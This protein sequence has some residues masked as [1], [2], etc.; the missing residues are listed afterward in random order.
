MPTGNGGLAP[1]PQNAGFKRPVPL[2][3]AARTPPSHRARFFRTVEPVLDHR[4]HKVAPALSRASREI[5]SPE[6]PSISVV[7]QAPASWE[8]ARLDYRRQD[9]D[10]LREKAA[11]FRELAARH[12]TRV[13]PE[14]LA[15]ADDLEAYAAEIEKRPRL[16]P[17][18]RVG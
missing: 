16:V 17:D 5:L 1:L 11:R 6:R 10:Y 12:M 9:A 8:G 7:R 2:R 18:E 15:I 14:M 3:R 4:G 13:S